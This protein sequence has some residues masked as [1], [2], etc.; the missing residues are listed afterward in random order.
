M[1][2]RGAAR[3]WAPAWAA[4]RQTKRL[5]TGKEENLLRGLDPSSVPGWALCGLSHQAVEESFS[6]RVAPSGTTGSPLIHMAASSKRDPEKDEEAPF[7][8]RVPSAGSTEV[9]LTL[10]TL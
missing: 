10:C 5:D 7:P 2:K 8:C 6:G 4:A 9:D 3:F 1:L